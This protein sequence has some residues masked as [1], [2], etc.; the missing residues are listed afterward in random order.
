MSMAKRVVLWSAPVLLLLL[1]ALSIYGAFLGADAAG[2]F[3]S[4]I[5]VLIFWV[6]IVA[7]FVLA[8]VLF[9]GLRA[10]PGLLALHVGPILVILGTTY[11]S[12]ISHRLRNELGWR[13][14]T[15]SGYLVVREGHQSNRLRGEDL[16]EQVGSLP[17]Q[18]KLNDF[19]L[20]RYEPEKD[21]WKLFCVIRNEDRG[22]GH[23]M[24]GGEKGDG[25]NSADQNTRQIPI[26]WNVG[27]EA[28]VQGT[29]IQVEVLRYIPHAKFVYEEGANRVLRVVPEGEEARTLPAREGETLELE[30]P[31]VKLRVVRVFSNLQVKG[32]GQNREVVDAEGEGNPALKVEVKKG[33]KEGRPIYLMPRFPMH[34]QQVERL[35]L[36]YQLPE[37]TG[38]R[39]TSG[40]STPAMKVRVRAYGKEMTDWLMAEEG[41]EHARLSLAPLADQKT[42]DAMTRALYL[43]RPGSAPKSYK[44]DLVVLEEGE[45]VGKKTV[46]VNNPLHYGGYHLYQSSYDRKNHAYTVLLVRSDD[47]LWLVYAGF[48]LLG[49]GAVWVCWGRPVKKW[50]TR[51]VR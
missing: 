36:H 13:A 1:A 22:A 16:E 2:E 21:R 34:G 33:D 40:S 4:S 27:T 10:R 41:Q 35:S 29:D 11:G 44:S 18:V 26:Q 37:P 7:D 39:P 19:R 42:D 30:N 47:G 32:R 5:S 51:R 17:F 23:G 12:Q 6:V 3:F 9:P 24:G 48:L 45:P 8:I 31:P 20:E 46:E 28:T 38:V 25:E 43:A 15:E 50:F 14:G 49:G